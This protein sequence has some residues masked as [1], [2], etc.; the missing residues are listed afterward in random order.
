[1]A[2]NTK[3]GSKALTYGTGS[4]SIIDEGDNPSE[5][6]TDS[7]TSDET[8]ERVDLQQPTKFDDLIE[9]LKIKSTKRPNKTVEI[10]WSP[11]QMAGCG[12]EEANSSCSKGPRNNSRCRTKNQQ[13][14][15]C[16]KNKHCIPD[17]VCYEDP[18]CAPDTVACFPG[19]SDKMNTM[20][21][22]GR[23]SFKLSSK[24]TTTTTI[25]KLACRREEQTDENIETTIETIDECGE[26]GKEGGGEE[27]EGEF[28]DDVQDDEY[29]KLRRK[30][31]KQNAKDKQNPKDK[32]KSRDKKKNKY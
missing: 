25:T 24:R 3:L 11:S 1:M 21:M 26:N 16:D 17:T 12:C 19:I 2:F 4:P 14:N 15:C 9:N 30:E 20:K 22:R 32:S 31:D 10:L 29:K 28:E 27:G 7:P 6:S 13:T 23:E 18:C 8:V 5:F